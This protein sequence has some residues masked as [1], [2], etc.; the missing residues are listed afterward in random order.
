[1]VDVDVDTD[2]DTSDGECEGAASG[3]TGGAEETHCAPHPFSQP[4]LLKSIRP[5]IY[6]C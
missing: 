2:S 5:V 3:E 4:R 6:Y 1:M